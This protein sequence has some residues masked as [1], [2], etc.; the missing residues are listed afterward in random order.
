[1]ALYAKNHAGALERGDVDAYIGT[2][3]PVTTSVVSGVGT[4]GGTTG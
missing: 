3:P 1:M 2:E 4:P